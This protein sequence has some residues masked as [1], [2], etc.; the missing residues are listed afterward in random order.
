MPV[1]YACRD[2]HGHLRRVP[3]GQ[4]RSTAFCPDCRATRCL[5]GTHTPGAKPMPVA[6]KVTEPSKPVLWVNISQAALLV[7]RR[8]QTVYDAAQNGRIPVKAELQGRYLWWVDQEAVLARW[9]T[10]EATA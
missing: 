6:V 3:A 7:G 10:R 1:A 5:F 2:A 8:Y 9:G 4:E